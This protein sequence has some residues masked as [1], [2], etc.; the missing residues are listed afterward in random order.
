MRATYMYGAGD[1]RL[2]DAP[3]PVIEQPTD[4]LIRVVRTCV[5]GSDL[6]TFADMEPSEQGQAMGHEAVG[7]VEDAGKDVATVKTG[8]LVIMPMFTADG[9]CS[10]CC[11]GL[12]SACRHVGFFGRMGFP[13]A[14]AEAIRVPHADANLVRVDAAPDDAIVPSL[15]TLSD[16]MATGH[17]AA[18][19]AEV[20]RG[21]KVAVVGDGAVGL[22]GVIAARRLGA[23]QIIVLGHHDDRTNL[24]REF[25]ATDVVSVDGEEAVEQ[26]RLLTG[27]TGAHS[28]LECVG[29]EAATA[30]AVEIARPGG[31]VSRVGVPHYAGIPAF[32]TWVKN[33]RVAGGPTPVRPYIDTLLRDVLDGTIQPGRVFD[34]TIELAKVADAYQAMARREALKVLLNP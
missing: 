10:F 26:V 14:Q 17:H 1:V 13:G 34:R 4:A 15:L 7:I 11:E 25:G 3:D 29:T 19:G 18:I 20:K 12:T 2:V 5:C 21:G 9:S 27:G 6:W 30:T 23:E 8:D 24:A 31:A 33:I 22:C 32:P 16:V 28:V